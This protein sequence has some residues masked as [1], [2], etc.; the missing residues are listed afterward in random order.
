MR[1]ATGVR[2]SGVESLRPMI[3]GSVPR[4]NSVRT[5]VRVC[6]RT[7][8]DTTTHS[9]A[10][11]LH[12]EYGA[13]MRI[14]IQFAFTSTFNPRVPGSISSGVPG[15]HR[16]GRPYAHRVSSFQVIS[17]QGER[18]LVSWEARDTMARKTIVELTDDLD[19][20]R[21]AETITFG[22][23]TRTY[24]IDLNAKNAKALRR[25][26]APYVES[27]RRVQ[28]GRRGRGRPRTAGSGGGYSTQKMREWARSQGIEV[29]DRGRIPADLAVR[30]LA[31]HR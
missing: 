17:L 23:D 24:I 9:C 26:L 3:G 6:G 12:E 15:R 7:R 25:V 4:G 16:A 28:P 30:F 29:A 21:A 18:P 14:T 1:S 27:G 11:D 5:N 2:D 19:G 22:L 8:D 20:G 10:V 31:A 13:S